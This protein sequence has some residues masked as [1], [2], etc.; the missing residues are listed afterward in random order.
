MS[1]SH[2]PVP[3]SAPRP[4]PASRA[5]PTTTDAASTVADARPDATAAAHDGAV[6][7]RRFGTWYVAEHHLINMKAYGWTIV[8]GSIGNPLLY[9]IGIGMGLAAFINQPIVAGEESVTYVQFV[10]PALLATAAVTISTTE[11]TYTVMSGFKWRKLFWGMNATPLSPG[12]IAHGLVLAVSMRMLAT[13]AVY[14]LIAVGFGAIPRPGPGALMPL[15]GLLGGL[16][17]GLPLLAWAATLREDSGQFALVQ[18]FIFTPMFLFS[19]TFYPLD[20]LPGWLSWIGWISP[21]W[22]AS[23]LGRVLSYGHPEPGWMTAAHVAILLLFAVAGWILADR[24]FTR[25]LRG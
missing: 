22:H 23:E 8:V 14:Y 20:T 7:P 19:G 24:M 6:K 11:F 21:L 10:A 9:L 18:R 5:Q 16:A 4:V 25:R 13:A 12:Q 3:P 15:V 1:N 2:P 17:F